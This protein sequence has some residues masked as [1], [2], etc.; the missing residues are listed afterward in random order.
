MDEAWREQI[1]E[2]NAK[3]RRRDWA[4]TPEERLAAAEELIRSSLQELLG[5]P[6]AYQAY[7]KRRHQKRKLS[8]A[9]QREIEHRGEGRRRANSR[10]LCRFWSGTAGESW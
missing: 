9:S 3:R 7:L 2:T 5:N 8:N 1:A 10:K 4:L 6:E